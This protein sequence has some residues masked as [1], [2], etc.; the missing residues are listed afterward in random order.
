MA[1]TIIILNGARESARAKRGSL[2]YYDI[3]GG[4]PEYRCELRGEGGKYG[5]YGMQTA[6]EA[7]ENLEQWGEHKQRMDVI[8]YAARWA[9]IMAK[10]AERE[11]LAREWRERE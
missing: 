1:S 5:I 11:E 9:P 4:G 6:K 3:S 10:Q 7:L 8:K 2:R